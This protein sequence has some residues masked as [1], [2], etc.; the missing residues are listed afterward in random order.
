MAESIEELEKRIE[1]LPRGTIVTKK[2]DGKPYF[3]QQYKENKKTVSNFLSN[4]EAEKMRPLIEERRELQKQLREMK[5]SLPSITKPD[6]PPLSS[7][8]I[9][10]TIP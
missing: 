7:F 9:T 3:Y 8:M 10:F 2:I 5:K 6:L 1:V 4:D